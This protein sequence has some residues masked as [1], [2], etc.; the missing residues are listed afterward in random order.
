MTH[1]V[2][3]EKPV[4]GVTHLETFDGGSDASERANVDPHFVTA[5]D[6]KHVL[7]K[8]DLNVM[9]VFC[10]IVALQFVSA[11]RTLA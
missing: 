6:S 4:D 8:A 9:P 2:I 5:A 11:R 7:R 10:A 3:D 1:D